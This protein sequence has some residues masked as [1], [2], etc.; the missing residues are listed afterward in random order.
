MDKNDG[1]IHSISL[2][3][4]VILFCLVLLPCS[5][6]AQ[7]CEP[8]FENKPLLAERQLASNNRLG[9]SVLIATHPHI[10]LQVVLHEQNQYRVYKHDLLAGT[11]ILVDVTNN[12]Q[13]LA[14]VYATHENQ[15]ETP[16]LS[17]QTML[18]QLPLK[19][20]HN[21][22]LQPFLNASNS[23]NTTLSLNSLI[24]LLSNAPEL[25]KEITNSAY[26][27]LIAN[28][29][30]NSQ[31]VELKSAFQ[32]F[33]MLSFNDYQT[34]WMLSVIVENATIDRDINLALEYFNRYANMNLL[35][36][37]AQFL[38]QLILGSIYLADN[39]LSQSAS[40]FDQAALLLNGQ[41]NIVTGYKI[42][43][44]D[45]LGHLHL[46]H[47]YQSSSQ[48]D[49]TTSL[50]A[51]YKALALTKEIQDN[52]KSSRVL[53]N[54]AWIH[55]ANGDLNHALRNY[56]HSQHYI[57]DEPDHF[58]HIYIFRNIGQ[59][60]LSTGQ[61][62]RALV[63]LLAALE[64]SENKMPFWEARLFCLVG[65]ANLNLR[66]Y[67][68]ALSRIETCETK[69]EQLVNET[70]NT[71]YVDHLIEARILL[72]RLQEALGNQAGKKLLLEKLT[73][74]PFSIEDA[75]LRVSYSMFMA[76]Q[77]FKNQE[78]ADGN[79]WLSSAL[80]L[81]YQSADPTL[82]VSIHMQ[83]AMLLSKFDSERA[84]QYGNIA[85]D[86]L[87]TASKEQ[88]DKE[89]TIKWKQQLQR[90]F[91]F[92]NEGYIIE[93]DWEGL[94]AFHHKIRSRSFNQGE[95]EQEI[96]SE[97]LR[98]DLD[99]ISRLALRNTSDERDYSNTLKLA[100]KKTKLA[101]SANINATSPIDSELAWYANI[102]ELRENSVLTQY[103]DKNNSQNLTINDYQKTLR[104]DQ[105][106]LLLLTT[107]NDYWGLLINQNDFTAYEI[108]NIELTEKLV[109]QTLQ[110]ASS[111]NA[112]FGNQK[113]RISEKFLPANVRHIAS[114]EL[115]IV[116]T[117]GLYSVPFSL[118]TL[119][120]DAQPDSSNAFNIVLSH[121]IPVI[122]NESIRIKTDAK[123][124]IFASPTFSEP[125]EEADNWASNLANLPWSKTEIDTVNKFF[126]NAQIF[127]AQDAT[128]KQFLSTNAQKAQILHISTHSYY[129]KQTPQETGFALSASNKN[130]QT[131]DAFVTQSDIQHRFYQNEL[132]VI[133]GCETAMGEDA[134]L[135]GHLSMSSAF[136]TSGAKQVIGT[137]W[138]ISD[139]ASALFMRYFYQQLATH[140]DASL[141]LSQAR[142]KM[143]MQT[144]YKHPFY[145]ASYVLIQ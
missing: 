68:D 29:I 135:G 132:V 21:V 125:N 41:N 71:I 23:P 83:S 92:M 55:K 22:A 72:Y 16:F 69:L 8:I 38:Q 138:P 79:E 64:K 46:L 131:I 85:I 88:L 113:K 101:W 2:K 35:D 97:S 19:P 139:K 133:N 86:L 82:K 117:T 120:T 10:R 25:N 142:T 44:F 17:S 76:R 91:S 87:T 66:Q 37:N 111:A 40:V 63:F 12:E 122:S 100:I 98:Q 80:S 90:F 137:L 50:D 39:K 58:R 126:N 32:Q 77:K 104:A 102:Q 33:E 145:W 73:N 9:S 116:P 75:D 24:A 70:N 119:K 127:Q 112:P 96:I 49:L 103:I 128:R 115:Y 31:F 56:F 36:K 4:I 45:S 118:L 28:L 57:E 123:V 61:Y 144:R 130:G 136:L 47:F 129:N 53:S 30:R 99:D 109:E 141:S 67:N 140:G 65:E 134:G 42:D 84:K 14:C 78:M 11:P 106:I 95:S 7:T 124:T 81:S 20:N 114:S 43:Y 13:Q 121:S 108:G 27:T 110:L 6:F 107:N 94:F 34:L 74:L 51:E 5:I 52:D 1:R 54:I 3:Q 48:S 89:Q 62:R 93:Q 59:L 26:Q 15:L 60:A 105:S 143:R 18:Q